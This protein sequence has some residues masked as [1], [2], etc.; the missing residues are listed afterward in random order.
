MCSFLMEPFSLLSVFSKLSGWYLTALLFRVA[1]RL[2][3]NAFN[4]LVW[5]P[6][7]LFLAGFICI[8]YALFVALQGKELKER[9]CLYV[10]KCVRVCA[11]ARVHSSLSMCIIRFP[12]HME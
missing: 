12:K 6:P 10:L 2:E 5:G 11:C 9:E 8:R 1:H 7:D 4:K 3:R